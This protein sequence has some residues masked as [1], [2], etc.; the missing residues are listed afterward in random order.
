MLYLPFG[1]DTELARV[2][3]GTT[4]DTN[5]LDQ[6][7]R[8]F[9][10]TLI[11]IPNQF[12]ATNPTAIGEGDMTAIWI[13]LPPRGF[14]LHTSVVALKL[15]ISLLPWFLVL[16]ILIEAG[17]SKPCTG[18][19]CLTSHGIEATSEGVFFSE[20]STVGLQVVLGDILA[21]HPHPQAFVT[22]EL[23][24]TNSLFDGSKLFLGAIKLVLVDQHVRLLLSR[25]WV[26]YLI[27][28][29]IQIF[30]L[31]ERKMNIL[32]C[33]KVYPCAQAP[34]AVGPFIPRMNDGGFLGRDL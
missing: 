28:V 9:L 20:N 16:A 10:D 13:K 32:L 25:I 34:K 31:E 33:R 7:E 26:Y 6:L 8:K 27:C 4:D 24:N 1:I 23:D 30:M 22:D 14:V 11:G 18:S 29:N 12:E 2:A 3:I 17:D 21:I 5:A 19:R 15:R